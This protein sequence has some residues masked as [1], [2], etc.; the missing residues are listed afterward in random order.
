MSV[1]AYD[2]FDALRSQGP[3][4]PTNWNAMPSS[5]PQSQGPVA[6][7][8][9]FAPPQ[10]YGTLP[11]QIP[12]PL[13][14][15]EQ[16]YSGLEPPIESNFGDSDPQEQ[17]QD[18]LATPPGVNSTIYGQLVTEQAYIDLNQQ[19]Q[20]EERQRTAT[21]SE[22]QPA[23]P[24]ESGSPIQRTASILGVSRSGDS[25]PQYGSHAT[26]RIQPAPTNENYGSLPSRN[27]PSPVANQ[28][29]PQHQPTNEN[30][31]SLPSRNVPNPL[32]L[33]SSKP[34]PS[35]ENYGTLPARIPANSRPS[36]SSQTFQT[37]SP[38]PTNEN[39][40]TLPAR[41]SPPKHQPTNENYGNLPPRTG[42]LSNS[43]PLPASQDNYG[44]LPL[45]SGS[46]TNIHTISS[47]PTT[48]G[49]TL[50]SRTGSSP[51]VT[52]VHTPRSNPSTPTNENYGTLPARN[53]APQQSRTS[54]NTNLAN[55]QSPQPTNENYGT[56]PARVPAKQSPAVQQPAHQPANENYGSLP[57]RIANPPTKQSP[58]STRSPVAQNENYGTLPARSNSLNSVTPKTA[59]PS[60]ENYG[61]LPPRP[62]VSS[63]T[64]G[65][66][67]PVKVAMMSPPPTGDHYGFISPP[68]LEEN[69]MRSAPRPP[70]NSSDNYGSIPLKPMHPTISQLKGGGKSTWCMNTDYF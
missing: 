17:Q 53:F 61:S 3:E 60:N 22:F 24:S 12:P 48:S 30:Y 56:L 50:P 47:S 31:G 9:V 35:T 10:N 14:P 63:P 37:P 23:R 28:P 54:S 8:P 15:P 69:A 64:I 2:N 45:R 59:S 68:S 6:P 11:R 18:I 26:L 36:I 40:G 21:K 13:P 65:R 49:G 51:N 33:Q 19:V 58:V 38:Q 57:P 1:K 25:H 20:T 62:S 4:D 55:S 52:P 70:V 43:T 67:S 46:N 41:G 29:P 39:Y 34:Q 16:D 42:G 66:G 5:L 7:P 44:T 27:F 32:V